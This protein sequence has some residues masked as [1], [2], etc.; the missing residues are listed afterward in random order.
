[1]SKIF[2]VQGRGS[3]FQNILR[4]SFVHVLLSRRR[5]NLYLPDLED[6]RSVRSA[7]FLFSDSWFSSAID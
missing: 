2:K 3:E 6:D 1:M 7:I 4:T 5:R